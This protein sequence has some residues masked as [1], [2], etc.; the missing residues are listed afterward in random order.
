MGPGHTIAAEELSARMRVF[1]SSVQDELINERTAVLE[2]V[3]TDSFLSKHVQAVLFE[4]QPARTL[5]AA[6]AYL[7]DLASCDVYVGILGFQYGRVA[8]D[9]L[10][11]THREYLKAREIGLP[12]LVFVRGHS[13]QDKKREPEIT[14]LFQQIRNSRKG[15]TY[16]RF[17]HYRDLKEKVRGA[18]ASHPRGEGDLPVRFGAD[19]VSGYSGGRV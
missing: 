15:H 18:Y 17:D 6:D 14:T 8:E 16:R 4:K 19:G 1:V 9:G 13:G 7:S 11:A 2:L 12:I 10:S 5:P 3:N